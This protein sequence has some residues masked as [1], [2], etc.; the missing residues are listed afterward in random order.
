MCPLLHT[1]TPTT[2]RD[3][4]LDARPR[5]VD[6]CDVRTLEVRRAGLLLRW[7]PEPAKRV[8]KPP[9]AHDDAPGIGTS[10]CAR[11]HAAPGHN[12]YPD[13]IFAFEHL[14]DLVSDLA[15]DLL[16]ALLWRRR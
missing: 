8:C 16:F 11:L 5:T 10:E 6:V 3:L 2:V 4:C 1:H 7:A 12:R 15:S 14:R 13:L 9:P